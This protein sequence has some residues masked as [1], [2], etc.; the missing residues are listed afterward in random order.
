MLLA[1]L[2][3]F[4]SVITAIAGNYDVALNSRIVGGTNA[5]SKQFPFVVQIQANGAHRCAG[6]I[7][8][9]KWIVT[10]AA[11]VYGFTT[12]QLKIVVGQV[13]LTAVDPGE[14]TI[15]VITNHFHEFYDAIGMRNNIAMLQVSKAINLGV[16]SDA[17]IHGDLPT[18]ENSG[19]LLGWGN[20]G[21]GGISSN[22]QFTSVPIINDGTCPSIDPNLWDPT[23]MIC[24]GNATHN[25]CYGD[26]SS[27]L[28]LGTSVANYMVVGLVSHSTSCYSPTA[29]IRLSAYSNWMQGIGGQPTE[30]TP[31]APATSTTSTTSITST[32]PT[33]SFQ[34]CNQASAG[35][36]P[37]VVAVGDATSGIHSCA[38][39]IYNAD[40]VVTTASCADKLELGSTVIIAGSLRLNNLGTDY[41][42]HAKRIVVNNVGDIA[43]IETLETFK[44]TEDVKFIRFDQANYAE[45]SSTAV[46]WASSEVGGCTP[47]LDLLWGLTYL[48]ARTSD[49]AGS[50]PNFDAST[51]I[52][53]GP[54][55]NYA[56]A[57]IVGSCRFENG[58]P[59]V[60][61]TP[62]VVIGIK[63]TV[64][65][66]CA[67]NVFTAYTRISTFFQWLQLN[68]G[69]Q[70]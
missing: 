45:P 61:G 4:S 62:P 12:S 40:Y 1:L 5:A 39:F 63:S 43:L 69:P 6:Y 25:A 7:Y 34:T 9:A 51:M 27:P 70:P 30:T 8:N 26:A 11:C 32:T 18:T 42:Y 19:L 22:L 50:V 36:F 57:S 48:S 24:A 49:C 3:T 28:V 23:F 38:G 55:N 47:S 21:S 46:G 15:G 37:F 14:E 10:T 58:A 52:C 59:L 13:S 35:Q 67:G 54:A 17:V 29:F 16:Y 65:P 33:A 31:T 60:Q 20:S 53:V 56:S 44:F 66:S 41:I 2:V 68:A 64:E